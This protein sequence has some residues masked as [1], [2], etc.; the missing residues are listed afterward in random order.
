MELSSDLKDALHRAEKIASERRHVFILLRDAFRAIEEVAGEEPAKRK[1]QFVDETDPSHNANHT[2]G[3]YCKYCGE[4]VPTNDPYVDEEKCGYK[5][6]KGNGFG[7]T[8]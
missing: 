8:H 2:D 6:H 1:L 4:Q 3:F 7:V 5:E